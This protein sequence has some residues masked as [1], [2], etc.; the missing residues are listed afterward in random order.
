[1]LLSTALQIAYIQDCTKSDQI[2]NKVVDP[3]HLHVLMRGG[4]IHPLPVFRCHDF[5]CC[6][7][8]HQ[9]HSAARIDKLT[10][11]SIRVSSL[12]GIGELKI[13]HFMIKFRSAVQCVSV[14][15][16][17]LSGRR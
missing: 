3:A 5:E 10:V 8:F 12:P 1:M 9:S 13:D 4:L 6:N 15:L 16:G 14:L 7:Q 2:Q 17:T 11:P